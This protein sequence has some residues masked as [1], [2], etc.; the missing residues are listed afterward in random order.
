MKAKD[1]GMDDNSVNKFCEFYASF[2]SIFDLSLINPD[3][4]YVIVKPMGFIKALEKFLNCICQKY[5]NGIVPEK[6]CKENLRDDWLAIM[7]ALISVNLAT[8]V[9]NT[10]L[11]I[12]DPDLNDIYYFI[13]LN[14]KGSLEEEADP[15][16]IHLLTSVNTFHVFKQATF[17]KYLLQSL[18]QSKLVPCS[19]PNQIIIK[20][21]STNTTITLVSHSPTIRLSISQ[22]NLRVCSLLIKACAEIAKICKMEINCQLVMKLS[23]CMCSSFIL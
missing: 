6:A 5:E 19:N 16:A 3:Y 22:A 13:P 7:E 21:K 23:F 18:Q 1:C 14:R 15:T 20:E 9:S 12:S 11:D 8:R 17:A 4:P 2:G 10:Q